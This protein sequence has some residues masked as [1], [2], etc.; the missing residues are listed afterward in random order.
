[1]EPLSKEERKIFDKLSAR[2]A[3]GEI[4]TG[5]HKEYYEYCVWK[6]R[7]ANGSDPRIPPEIELAGRITG[8]GYEAVAELEK[9]GIVL[10][11]EEK[12]SLVKPFIIAGMKI[13]FPGR[14]AGETGDKFSQ[15]ETLT[16][17]ES[18]SA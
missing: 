16:K 1:M 7:R 2:T 12:F 4:L 15:I 8:K 17:N 14:Y 9:E 10:S 6:D 13:I 5:E 3:S 18:T 11:K